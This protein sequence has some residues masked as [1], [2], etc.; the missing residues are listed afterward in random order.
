MIYISTP[1]RHDDPSV[2]DERIKETE[3]FLVW[4]LLGRKSAIS[5]PVQFHNVVMSGKLPMDGIFWASYYIPILELS[6]VIYVLMIDGWDKSSG[7]MDEISRAWENDIPV[8]YFRKTSDAYEQVKMV[9][10]CKNANNCT[11]HYCMHMRPHRY[12]RSCANNC[13]DAGNNDGKCIFIEDVNQ[14]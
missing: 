14:S 8:K 2:M 13:P 10:I 11:E 9:T 1:Y 4:V 12:M 3:D 7:V 6:S 5:I